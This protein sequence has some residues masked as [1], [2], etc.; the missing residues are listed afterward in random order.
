M[1]PEETDEI[2]QAT[3]PSHRT[4]Q[5]TAITEVIGRRKQ[6]CQE[7][8][9]N[10]AT[11]INDA[12]NN[13]LQKRIKELEKEL[14]TTKA[15][16]MDLQETIYQQTEQ[17]QAMKAKSTSLIEEAE[18]RDRK[19][20]IA[21]REMA[22]LKVER[23]SL[24][25]EV[26]SEAELRKQLK[27][28]VQQKDTERT[29]ATSIRYN[30]AEAIKKVQFLLRKINDIRLYLAPSR[31]R[32]AEANFEERVQKL[33]A[34]ATILQIFPMDKVK[35]KYIR[36]YLERHIMGKAFNGMI[37]EQIEVFTKNFPTFEDNTANT[38]NTKIL[39]SDIANGKVLVT[40]YLLSA[41]KK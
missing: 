6:K 26:H 5:R 7:V 36:N 21:N 17:I 37:R 11:Q 40:K 15:N 29:K 30:T 32:L 34:N 1:R 22:T 23:D 24:K 10:P 27:A 33:F 13:E 14:A 9:T 2:I 18:I 3:T 19:L 41:R 25:G 16:T 31:K 8:A 38:E 39:Y 35:P 12:A 28:A 20:Q 4:R